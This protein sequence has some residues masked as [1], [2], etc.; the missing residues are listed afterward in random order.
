MSSVTGLL[1][2][3]GLVVLEA[4]FASKPALSFGALLNK[5]SLLTFLW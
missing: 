3:A 2:G 5:A 1:T 4:W